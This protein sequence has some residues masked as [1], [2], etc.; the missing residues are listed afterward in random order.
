MTCMYCGDKTRNENHVCDDC[1][2]ETERMAQLA[3]KEVCEVCPNCGNEIHAFVLEGVEMIDCCPHCGEK[4]ILREDKGP[5]W[6]TLRK[7]SALVTAAIQLNPIV[8]DGEMGK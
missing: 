1:Q 2:A 3:E 6:R 7:L 8:V 5:C 4:N